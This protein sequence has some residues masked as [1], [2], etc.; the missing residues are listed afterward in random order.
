MS[1]SALASSVQ[2]A[3]ALEVEPLDSAFGVMI[4]GVDLSQP[5]DDGDRELIRTAV[6]VHKLAVFRD[7][8]L[9]SAQ[10]AAFAARFGDLYRHPTTELHPEIPTLQVIRPPDPV[11]LARIKAEAGPMQISAGYHAD[12]SWRLAPAWAGV[13][14]PIRLPPVGGDTIWVDAERAF[15]DLDD[16]VKERLRGLHV[17]HDFSHA[18]SPIGRHYPLVCHPMVHRYGAT[19]AEALWVNFA[20]RPRIIGLSEAEN[21]DL[22]QLVIDQYDKPQHQLRLRWRLGMVAFWDNRSTVHIAVRDYGDFPRVLE[23]A[24]VEDQPAYAAL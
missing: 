9:S 13:L 2:A 12:T 15:M 24:L 3:R 8:W 17:T 20:A 22:L 19:R 18:L 1:V 5:L 21:R 23:R 4:D 10:H 14:R 16:E 7:Q 6:V 11:K